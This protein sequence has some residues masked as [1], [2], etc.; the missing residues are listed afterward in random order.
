VKELIHF[1]YM[2]KSS[3]NILPNLSFSVP[4]YKVSQ[5]MTLKTFIFANIIPLIFMHMRLFPT[6][7]DCIE[8]TRQITRFQFIIP[9]PPFRAGQVSCIYAK[10]CIVYLNIYMRFT[11]GTALLIP[12]ARL[13]WI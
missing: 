4:Q 10:I 13:L 9:N 3:I 12:S 7:S 11:M 1:H 8:Y 5:T 6:Y 2:E